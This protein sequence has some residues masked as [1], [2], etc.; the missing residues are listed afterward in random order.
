MHK[1]SSPVP[2]ILA[3]ISWKWNI[4]YKFSKKKYRDIRFDENPSSGSRV[5]PC[6]QTAGRRV[7]TKLI[8][9]FEIFELKK[10]FLLQNFPGHGRSSLCT[11]II[12][13]KMNS[14]EVNSFVYTAEE[15]SAAKPYY[16]DIMELQL[17]HRYSVCFRGSVGSLQIASA[18]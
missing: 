11:V 10:Y 18:S 5:V 7:K 2:V 1:S 15:R 17:H 8:D 9:A 12:S 6:G 3:R 16:W 13:D 4:P 14:W